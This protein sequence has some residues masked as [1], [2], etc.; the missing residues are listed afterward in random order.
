MRVSGRSRVPSPPASTTPFIL[1]EAPGRPR[2]GGPEPESGGRG[3][4][5]VVPIRGTPSQRSEADQRGLHA[6]ETFV[7]VRLVG[8]ARLHQPAVT[9]RDDAEEGVALQ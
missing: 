3:E 1:V 5:G 8:D 2:G 9:P 4:A 6:E 7:G